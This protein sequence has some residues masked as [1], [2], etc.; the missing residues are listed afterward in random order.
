MIKYIIFLSIIAI[1]CH[2]IPNKNTSTESLH[3][4][5]KDSS[6]LLSYE[7]PN[8]YKHEGNVNARNLNGELNN[9]RAKYINTNK[10]T[11]II[12]YYTPYY[13]QFLYSHLE[14]QQKD[15]SSPNN[16]YK[17]FMHD[18][19][20]YYISKKSNTKDG[21]GNT[22]PQISY[23]TY[24]DFFHEKNGYYQYQIKQHQNTKEVDVKALI[25][26]IQFL[27]AKNN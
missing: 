16:D 3:I 24:I 10:E 5:H 23:T 14:N 27:D 1:S 9:I 6:M 26:S 21:K 13:G 18:G 4:R 17:E 15:P 2:S 19:I 25:H 7:L 20:I 11:I 8:D 12:E 22:L